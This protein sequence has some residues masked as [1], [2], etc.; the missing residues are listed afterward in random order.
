VHHV[1]REAAKLA[2]A[3]G[4]RV[5][6]ERL[7]RA[8]TLDQ[9][10]AAAAVS[11][12]MVVSVEQ[13][14]VN[15]SVGTLL[16]L[17]DALG[18]GLPALVEPPRSHRVTV[19]RSG[20]G[21]ELW[22]GSAGGRGVL[23]AATTRPDVVELWDWSLGPGDR[24]TSEAHAAGTKE[25]VHVLA[26]SMTVE[27]DDQLV[28]LDSGDAVAFPGDVD[29]TYVNPGEQLARFSLTVFEPGRHSPR[30]EATHD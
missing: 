19:T 7:A 25:L 14:T 9:L 29:H 24:H 23:V 26:G 20:E 22:R 2:T 28:T 15:P 6:Q 16:R 3:I 8:W 30:S 27:V 10:A 11:R 12:R 5:K 17:S 13:G 4:A 1:D 21:A 18:V